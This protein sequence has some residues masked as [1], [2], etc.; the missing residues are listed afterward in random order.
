MS[1]LVCIA[2][3]GVNP[4]SGHEYF[5]AGGVNPAKYYYYYRRGVDPPQPWLPF[6]VTL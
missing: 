3:G 5:G 4:P 1:T 6:M 2:L